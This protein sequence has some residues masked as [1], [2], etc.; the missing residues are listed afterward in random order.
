VRVCDISYPLLPFPNLSTF[1]AAAG[2]RKETSKHT[3][4]DMLFLP[5]RVLDT[6][7][8]LQW[9]KTGL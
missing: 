9:P 2:A 8:G 5:N 6:L 4:F 1:A 7:Q 3:L